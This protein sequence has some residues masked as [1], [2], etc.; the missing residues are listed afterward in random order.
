[1]KK[2]NLF[3]SIL[4][5]CSFI[6]FGIAQSTVLSTGGNCHSNNFAVSYSIGQIFY[7]EF[8]NSDIFLIDGVQ[9]PFEISTDS[10]VNEFQN[11]G[12]LIKVY[13]NPAQNNLTLEIDYKLF[14]LLSYQLYDLNS[15]ILVQDNII[16]KNTLIDV[17]N[18]PPA[19]YFLSISYNH[20]QVKTFKIIKYID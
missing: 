2:S 10:R 6:Q 5:T 1:M 7:L 12:I 17:S 20:I 15:K 13:P 11:Q 16:N 14:F 8:R 18:L 19:T 4:L 3:L 9:Q